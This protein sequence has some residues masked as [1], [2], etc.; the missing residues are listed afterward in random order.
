MRRSRLVCIVDDRVF[1]VHEA[2][3]Y[4]KQHLVTVSLH[5]ELSKAQHIVCRRGPSASLLLDRRTLRRGKTSQRFKLV[6]KR[7]LLPELHY[8][9]HEAGTLRALEKPFVGVRKSDS[10]T[11][12]DFCHF[13]G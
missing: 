10:K 7:M 4:V 2:G 13:C 11:S 3:T 6:E 5:E 1:A 9:A 12:F 8:A